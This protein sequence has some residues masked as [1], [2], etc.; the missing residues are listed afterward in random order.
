MNSVVSV[1]C[2]RRNE[3]RGQRATKHES[4]KPNP[5]FLL[6]PSCSLL[7]AEAVVADRRIRLVVNFIFAIDEIAP[8]VM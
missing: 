5:P 1:R 6:S 4:P 2:R 3:G 8:N 7:A